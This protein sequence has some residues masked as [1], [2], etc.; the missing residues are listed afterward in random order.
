MTEI[1]IDVQGAGMRFRRHLD[2]RNSLSELVSRGRSKKYEDFWAVR[3]V[4]FRV[5]K[6]SV[7]GLIGHNGS[8]K[9]TLLKMINGIYP[10]TIGTITTKGRLSSLIELGAGF[11]PEMTGRENIRL[12]G[13]IIGLTRKE[14]RD[15]TEAII[16]FS[17]IGE[18]INEPV[19]HYSSGMYVRLGFSVAVHMQPDV[20]LIDE[21]LAVG[22][23]EFQRKCLDHL[24]SL[25]R[26][27]RTI[28][29]VSHALSQIEAMCDEVTWMDHGAAQQTGPAVEVAAAYLAQVNSQETSR[30]ERLV[31]LR[32]SGDSGATTLRE[33]GAQLRKVELLAMDGTSIGHAETGESFR[34]RLALDSASGIRRELI[35]V[36]LQHDSGPLVTMLDSGRADVDLNWI[37]PH[38]SVDVILKNN[39]LMAG[40]YRVH[41]DIF[42]ET[43]IRLLD[44][45]NRALEFAVRSQ[46]AELGQS[47]VELPCEFE[48]APQGGGEAQSSA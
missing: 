21:V 46:R 9:S 39:P 11:H 3:D 43:G 18:F 47:L 41:V 14:I 26:S 33:G 15:A 7:Y 19:K 34:I 4:T 31:A 36:S 27:G 1:A 17:G 38:G 12:N 32:P 2:K 42:D 29:I 37:G 22:D 28:L 48:V 8:G 16:D 23:E 6:G 13:T 30:S 35:R 5:S 20:L 24:S 45:W 10:P 40:R 25:R 44:T